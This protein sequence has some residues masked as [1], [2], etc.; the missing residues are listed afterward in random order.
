MNRFEVLLRC[1]GESIGVTLQPDERGL[2]ELPVQ[3]QRLVLYYQA[4]AS[5][6]LCFG[7]VKTS[8]TPFPSSL[9]THAL[10]LNLFGNGTHGF[11]LGLFH[12][13]LLL[14]GVLPLEVLSVEQLVEQLYLLAV[15][16][17][18]VRREL[19]CAP[20]ASIPSSSSGRDEVPDLARLLR[21]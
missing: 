17:A 3:G 15:Q 6:L 16:I 7:V 10:T 13:T 21:I 20:E 14:S 4:E 18:E 9:L 12:N 8:Q 5:L 1:L 11:S 19:E 2:C